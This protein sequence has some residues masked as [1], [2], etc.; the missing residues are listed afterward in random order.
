M[1]KKKISLKLDELR[2]VTFAPSAAVAEP[3]GGS[4]D[5][6]VSWWCSCDPIACL[7]T[8]TTSD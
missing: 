1:R 8:A 6:E 3:V 2:V 4:D 7:Q 5:S